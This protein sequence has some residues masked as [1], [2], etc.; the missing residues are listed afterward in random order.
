VTPEAIHLPIAL[1]IGLLFVLPLW[2]A[3]RA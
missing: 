1:M 3:D 2:L